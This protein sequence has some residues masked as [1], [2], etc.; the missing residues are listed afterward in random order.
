MF[1]KTK[2]AELLRKATGSRSINQ[3]WL[4][5]EVSATYISKLQRGL[6]DKPPSPEIIRKLAD[7]AENG[8][9]YEELMQAAGHIKQYPVQDLMEKYNE[10]WP[11]LKNTILASLTDEQR[12]GLINSVEKLTGSRMNESESITEYF[13]RHFDS[14]PI[15]RQVEALSAIS[16]MID[17]VEDSNTPIAFQVPIVERVIASDDGYQLEKEV[18][19]ETVNKNKLDAAY[20]HF[21]LRITDNSVKWSA[22]LQGDLVLVKE[23]PH[24]ENGLAVVIIDD[25]GE[26]AHIK[27]ISTNKN[28]TVLHADPERA[29]AVFIGDDTKK[30]HII[31]EILEVRRLYYGGIDYE[32]GY[33]R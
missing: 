30:I 2:F 19:V 33:L 4:R 18:G 8:V 3:Y 26:E 7:H 23:T 24:V 9:T 14:L 28:T 29:P 27:R 15:A 13:V 21:W 1:D 20:T 32:G 6:V 10:I 5:S 12:I 16:P 25:E 31:G 11:N 22:I 17:V